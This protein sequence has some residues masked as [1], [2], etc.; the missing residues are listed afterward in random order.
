[1]NHG[2]T[3]IVSHTCTRKTGDSFCIYCSHVFF[4]A[5]FALLGHF[6]VVKTNSPSNSGQSKQAIGVKI[7]KSH[8]K[9][10]ERQQFHREQLACTNMHAWPKL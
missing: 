5:H 8:C 9:F 2:L 4:L 3:N 1:M 6:C 10:G 7:P